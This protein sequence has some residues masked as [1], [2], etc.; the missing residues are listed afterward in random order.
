MQLALFYNAEQIW[1]EE[2]PRI[3]LSLL[4]LTSFVMTDFSF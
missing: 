4:C 3:D 2:G 1:M